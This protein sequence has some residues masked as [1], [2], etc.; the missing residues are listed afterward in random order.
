MAAVEEAEARVASTEIQFRRTA[1]VYER[2]VGMASDY[3]RDR[4]AAAEARAALAKAQKEL[5]RLQ[6]GTWEKDLK[7]AEAAVAQAEAEVERVRTDIDRRTVRALTDG[8]VLQVNV[9]PGQFGAMAWKEPLIVLGNVDKLHVR[10]DIDEQDLPLFKPG[11][12]GDCHAQGAA[13]CRVS[14]GIRP[15]RSVRDPESEPD[16]QQHRAG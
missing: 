2:G 1:A 16:G 7:I 10:V 15:G 3:D 6:H 9:L 4:Y 5:E 13:G 11:A 8:Q 14:L 12:A